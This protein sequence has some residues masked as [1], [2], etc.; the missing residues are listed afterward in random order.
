MTLIWRLSGHSTRRSSKMLSQSDCGN[1]PSGTEKSMKWLSKEE[2]L[3]QV[4]CDKARWLHG[5]G[6][7]TSFWTYRSQRMGY[8]PKGDI[9]PP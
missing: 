3:V 6:C 9:H 7:Q 8:T 2:A 1:I 4:D 5:A